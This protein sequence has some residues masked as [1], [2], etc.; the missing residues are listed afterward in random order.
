MAQLN[1]KLSNL[2]QH[3][4]D[5]NSEYLEEFTNHIKAIDV[6]GATVGFS[7][8]MVNTI[9]KSRNPPLTVDT[10]TPSE[11]QEAI[12]EARDKYL[13]AAFLHGVDV[14][15]Y[16]SLLETLENDYLRDDKECYPSD[17]NKS[18][19]LI[20]NYKSDPR[21]ISRRLEDHSQDGLAFV[22]KEDEQKVFVQ[23]S[24]PV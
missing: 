3:K 18:Y 1:V 7:D 8:S 16:G 15:R 12:E 14:N 17:T 11:Y 5:S 20:T 4:Y 9:L 22:Q 2:R 10:A 24:P 23:H 6:C 13:A 21:N 19:E